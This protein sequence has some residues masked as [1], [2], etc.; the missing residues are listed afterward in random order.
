MIL[1]LCLTCISNEHSG[2]CFEESNLA[3]H[4]YR[5]L[6]EQTHSLLVASRELGD[7]YRTILE[8]VNIGANDLILGE[9][10][11]LDFLKLQEILDAGEGSSQSVVRRLL[12]DINSADHGG[13]KKIEGAI[14]R[15]EDV[16][17]VL[18]ETKA[19]DIR[20]GNWAV[21]VEQMQR[22]LHRLGKH[23]P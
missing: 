4:P 9:S 10:T 7:S 22:P 13:Y 14:S 15:Q 11:E 5:Q 17:E 1:S 21:T 19:S 18:S 20:A 23:L 16:W 12:C 6:R 3:Q 2:S 8:S